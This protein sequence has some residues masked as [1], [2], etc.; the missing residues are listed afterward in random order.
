MF[1][2]VSGLKSVLGCAASLFWS[3]AFI[4]GFPGVMAPYWK[5]QFGA[6][7]GA[8]G[9]ILFFVLAGAGIFMFLVGKWQEPLGIRRTITAGVIITSVNV[10]FVSMASSLWMIYAFAFVAGA[11]SCL[12]YI[13]SLTCV[14]RWYPEKRG[15]VSGAVNITFGLS[16]GLMSP[17]FVILMDHLGY[18]GMIL[19]LGLTSLVWGVF[20]SRFANVPPIHGAHP[21]FSD[22]GNAT[23][24][25]MHLDKLM[26]VREIIGSRSF[27]LLWLSWALQ[28]STGI[29]MVSLSTAY[30][31]SNN[32]PIESAVLILVSF[33][34]ASGIMRLL[35][36]M[37]SDYIGRNL[38]MS[39]SFMLS[40]LAYLGLSHSHDLIWMSIF[41][42]LVGFAFATLFTVSAP[43]VTDCFGIQNFGMVFGMVFTAYGF[44]SGPLGPALS[45]FILDITNDFSL[46][47]YYLSAFSFLASILI[48]FV[49]PTLKGSPK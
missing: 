38:T 15:F 14:Q 49:R 37:L 4:F 10:L 16:A 42:G 36:G 3:G 29:A 33:N 46:V 47:F 34:L 9:S 30:G 20:S 41:A 21:E 7:Q 40:G 6:S 32:Y 44:I 18:H 12:I 22:L 11:S 43:L 2:P 28:G 19:F 23:I 17:V 27:R 48:L 45:G 39:I 31:M 8:L 24:K 26:S 1:N 25:Q 5:N 13:P 35:S